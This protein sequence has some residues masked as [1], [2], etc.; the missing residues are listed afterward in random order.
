MDKKV[1]VAMSGGVD[2]SAAAAILC[3]SGYDCIGVTMKLYHLPVETT[4]TNTCCTLSD[5]EDARSVAYRLGMKYYVM[6]FTADFEREVIDRFVD[7]YERGETPNPCIDCNRY[8][9]FSQLY[10][11][12]ALLGCDAIATGH[13]ARVSYCEETGRWRL[14][15]SKNAAKDQSYVLYSMT[16]EQLAHTLFPLGE[17]ETKAE[18][19]QLAADC[20]L[21][22]AEKQDSQDI[23]FVPDGDYAA[24]IQQYTG[25]QYPHGDFI[26]PDGNRL[27][28]HHGMIGYTIGQ[29]RGLGISAAHP[30]Y[31]C[32]KCVKDNTIT[33]SGKEGL[34]SDSLVARDF[35]WIAYDGAP[36]KPILAMVKTRYHAKEA[37]AVVTPREDGT[38][39]VQFREP[40]RAVTPGQA[41]VLYQGEDVIGGGTI[42]TTKM[43]NF[44]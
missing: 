8:M 31:V 9:K 3:Q 26:D 34:Y 20:G 4:R 18:V 2:S 41:V 33:L 16:Q 27:G 35:N 37:E 44:T 29:R 17:F 14:Q 7:A 19:R 24:F 10:E 38:V 28:E 40:Q 43:V 36:E 23:C 30:L 42:S 21:L 22:N 25:K 5:A 1:L 6:N 15:K 13:Y 39:L 12:A 11:R 32:Q